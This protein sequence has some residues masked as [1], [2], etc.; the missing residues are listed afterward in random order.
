[1]STP[2]PSTSKFYSGVPLQSPYPLAR[3]LP[4]YY[5]HSA[6]T[7]FDEVSSQS[8]QLNGLILD[9]FGASPFLPVEL[10]NAGAA[11]IVCCNNPIL[12]I[13]IRVAALHPTPEEFQTVLA[14][15]SA[16]KKFDTRLETF[17]RSLYLSICNTCFSEVEVETYIWERD[18]SGSLYHQTYKQYRCSQCGSEGLFPITPQ[19]RQNEAR[20]PPR[21][22]IETQA[23]SKVVKNNDPSYSAVIEVLSLYP[24]RSLY[25]IVTILNKLAEL[26]FDQRQQQILNAL[27]IGAFDLTNSLWGTPS[28]RQ[29]PKQLSIPNQYT[30]MN[31]W[32]SLERS[33]ELWLNYFRE[34]NLSAVPAKNWPQLPKPGEI[35]IFPGRIRELLPQIPIKEFSAVVSTLPRPNQAFWTLCALWS[36]WLEGRELVKPLRS[37]LSRKR[38]DWGWHCRALATTFQEL[39]HYLPKNLPC[40]GLIE[41]YEANFL[42]AAL[43]AADHANL[44]LENLALRSDQGRAQI[45]W[46][47]FSPDHQTSASLLGDHS[48]LLAK[49]KTHIAESIHHH[50]KETLE[51]AAYAQTHAV[52]LTSVVHSLEKHSSKSSFEKSLLEIVPFQSIPDYP[53]FFLNLLDEAIQSSS[54]LIPLKGDEKGQEPHGWWIDSPRLDHAPLSDSVERDIFDYLLNHNS[55]YFWEIDQV[56]C[57]RFQQ[58]GVPSL[59]LIRE[60]LESYANYDPTRNRWTLRPEENPIQRSLDLAEIRANL[61]FLGNQLNYGVEGDLSLNW[62]NTNHA[63]VATWYIQSTA[64]ISNLLRAY[65]SNGAPTYFVIPGSRVNLMLYK[66]QRYPFLTHLLGKQIHIIRYRQIRWIVSQPDITHQLFAEWLATDPLKYQT[67]QLSLW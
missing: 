21:T 7:Y 3:F 6:T 27:L 54:F 32:L 25:A 22:L 48:Q 65:Y 2:T 62:F 34:T 57:S 13:Y 24:T 29:R 39:S 40:L 16:L 52:A 35:S 60:C 49:V 61:I 37:A 36:G 31:F 64:Q 56:I 19:D 26:D 55:V 17:F 30:E 18:S 51:P 38:Y 12:Q 66:L 41:E 20:L 11:V 58:V 5:K 53:N 9:P 28:K 43:F 10:A 4:P 45:H 42:A 15:I 23:A 33:L 47:T 50:I 59:A 14:E 1:M 46:R 63:K 44:W 8:N 67:S